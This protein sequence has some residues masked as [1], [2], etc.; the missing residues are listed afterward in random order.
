MVKPSA[1]GR[2]GVFFT[3]QK[4]H[5]FPGSLLQQVLYPTALVDTV[6]ATRAPGCLNVVHSKHLVAKC[7][8]E[9]NSNRSATLS[10]SEMQRL[11]VTRLFNHAPSFCLADE[12]APA[13]DLRLESFLYDQCAARKISMISTAHRP[14]VIPHHASVLRDAP[15]AHKSSQ[16]SSSSEAT[17]SKFPTDGFEDVEGEGERDEGEG[18][19]RSEGLNLKFSERFFEFIR[20]NIGKVSSQVFLT[21]FLR[22]AA[23]CPYGGLKIEIFRH[24]G[25]S[26]IAAMSTGNKPYTPATRNVDLALNRGDIIIALKGVR[27]V[28]PA[29]SCLAGA[30]PAVKVQRAGVSRF[31]AVYF[32]LGAVYY[33]NRVMKESGVDQRI[34]QDWSGLHDAAEQYEGL[35][36]RYT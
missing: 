8:L 5:V 10:S 21:W 23:M 4:P 14:S 3:P 36:V 34:V 28:C 11:N 25:T 24:Y 33:L 17:K 18:E 19:E 32:S 2:D 27:A 6:D 12:G 35:A 29:V 9:R 1:G 31:H 30:W 20:L 13:L 22:L 16:L 7:G 26:V 15:E